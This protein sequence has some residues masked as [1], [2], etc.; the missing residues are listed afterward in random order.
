MTSNTTIGL[1]S[2]AGVAGLVFLSGTAVLIFGDVIKGASL[3]EE[4]YIAAV[5]IAGTMMVG[6]LSYEA[7]LTGKRPSAI[8]FGFLFA[9]GTA[10]VVLSSAG[11]QGEATA[12]TQAQADAAE[13]ARGD[14]RQGLKRA[15]GMLAEAQAALAKECKSGR[16]KRCDGIQRTIDVYEAA[17]R[18]E[19]AKLDQIGPATVVAP[20]EE[21]VA[22]VIST[23]FNA[24]HARV[25]ALA[26]LIKPF[27]ISLFLEFGAI[28]SFGFAFRG[29]RKTTIAVIPDMTTNVS[30]AE[31]SEL[32]DLTNDDLADL[33]RYFS[34][35]H[36][37]TVI[38]FPAP[39]GSPNGQPNG[40]KGGKRNRRMDRKDA[41]L[42]DIVSRIQAGERFD[43]QEDLRAAL[44][45]KFGPVS[46]STLSNWLD[47]LDAKVERSQESLGRFSPTL[48]KLD[49]L[50][51]TGLGRKL[52]GPFLFTSLSAPA[53]FQPCLGV[54]RLIDRSKFL[55]LRRPNSPRRRSCAGSRAAP[56]T[57]PQRRTR[58]PSAVCADASRRSARR[59]GAPWADP[60]APSRLRCP[61]PCCGARCLARILAALAAPERARLLPRPG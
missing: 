18:G 2:L 11:R 44:S 15:Q 20:D 21:K 42:A 41:V 34:N 57:A 8:N 6:H 35:D 27:L 28:V 13:T 12:I 45:E 30:T 17:A 19:Q 37:A 36:S 14:A 25:K 32:N 47:E 58:H 56:G 22:E 60:G 33:K 59:R 10:L 49:K 38:A 23:I 61:G 1:R 55:A 54:Q 48:A 26:V 7:W 31:P 3:T 24:D 52:P 29:E 53:P 5:I 46:R 39:N 43:S 50:H 4:H 16:G 9:V 51:I 40:P